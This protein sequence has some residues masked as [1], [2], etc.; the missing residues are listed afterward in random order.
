M[1]VWISPQLMAGPSRCVGP[2]PHP[3]CACAAPPR[4][5]EGAWTPPR[6]TLLCRL[7]MLT[8]W[9]FGAEGRRNGQRQGPTPPF[10]AASHAWHLHCQRQGQGQEAAWAGP[11]ENP[12]DLDLPVSGVGAGW[13]WS[14]SPWWCLQPPA[15]CTSEGGRGWQTEKEPAFSVDPRAGRADI[16]RVEAACQEALQHAGEKQ[17]YARPLGVGSGEPG[18]GSLSPQSPRL[19]VGET[20]VPSTNVPK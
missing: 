4:P 11:Q 3:G 6:G 1:F 12:G 7:V 2:G 18:Q 19:A 10:L 15:M 20:T 5:P 13:W 14:Y 17:L 16:H 9:S 8:S